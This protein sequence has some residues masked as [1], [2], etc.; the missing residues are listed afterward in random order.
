[1]LIAVRQALALRVKQGEQLIISESVSSFVQ[2]THSDVADII[3]DMFL[4]PKHY[5]ILIQS[6]N[7]MSHTIY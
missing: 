5:V 1:M 4:E 3:D 2:R 6:I 7:K